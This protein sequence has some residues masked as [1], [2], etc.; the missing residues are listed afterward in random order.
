[1][2]PILR[3]RPRFASIVF[4]VY[5]HAM[6]LT[7]LVERQGALLTDLDDLVTRSRRR[8]DRDGAEGAQRRIQSIHDDVPPLRQQYS[9]LQP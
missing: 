8:C 9:C 4:E 1:M 2:S 7:F 5:Q 6:I 3:I